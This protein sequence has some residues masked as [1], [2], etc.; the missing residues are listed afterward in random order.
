MGGFWVS[1]SNEPAASLFS[2]NPLLLTSLGILLV[3]ISGYLYAQA[4]LTDIAPIKGIPVAP[5]SVP[6]FGHLKV[7]S[8]D[9]SSKFEKWGTENNWP[10]LQARLGRRRIL[11][12]NGFKE[13]QQWIVKNASATIDRPL[14]YTF[15]GVIS[16]SQGLS[17]TFTRFDT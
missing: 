11:V 16:K 9:H 8:L 4:F 17:T 5:G 7:L 15:H 10:V 2:H 3:L 6:F 12:L 14:F 1:A 13:A